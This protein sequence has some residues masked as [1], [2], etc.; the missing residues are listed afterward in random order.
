[1][2]TEFEKAIESLNCRWDTT[3]NWISELK[4]QLKNLAEN[5]EKKIKKLGINDMEGPENHIQAQEIQKNVSQM[6]MIVTVTWTL[7]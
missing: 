4:E 6:C 1:M 2:N 5:T 7:T 3:G